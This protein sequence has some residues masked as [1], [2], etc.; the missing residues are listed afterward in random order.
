M[1]ASKLHSFHIPVMGL[2]YTIDTPL[3][4][5]R[6]GISSVV[7]IIEDELVE[8][9]RK[10][11]CEK[12]NIS[13]VPIDEKDVDHRAKRITAYLNLM[14]KILIRQIESLKAGKFEEGSDLV[15]YF[16]MLPDSSPVKELYVL[17][18]K[19]SGSEKEVMQKNLRSKIVAGAIDVNIMTKL[20]KANYNESGEELPVEYCDAMAALRGFAL[21]DLNSSMVF[22]AGLNP[23]LYSYCEVFKDFFQDENGEFRKK[24][25]LKVSDYRSALIQGKFLAKKGLW[26]SEFRIESGLNCGGHAFATEGLLTGPILRE[27]K[28]KKYELVNELFEICNT[29]LREKKLKV[30]TER[31]ELKITFQ[32]GIGTAG[33]NQF[34]LEQYSLDATGW[35]SPFL[36]VPEVT[37]VDEKTLSLLANAVKQD[38]YLSHASPLG[39]PFNNFRRSTAEEQRRMRIEKG[40]PGSPCYKKFLAF[41]TEF[42]SMPI[43]T[44]SR[45]YQNLK[46]KKVK[47]LNLSESVLQ[48][49]IEAIEEKDCLCEGL[50]ASALIKNN[51]PPHHNLTAVT[52]CPGPN[53]AYFSGIFSLE[54]MVSHIYGRKN[55]LNS[56][57]RPNIF[58]NELAL[59]VDYLKQE[60][61]NQR[62]AITGRKNKY[63]T[64]FKENLLHGIQYYKSLVPEMKQFAK[65]QLDA[66]EK[67]LRRFESEITGIVFQQSLAGN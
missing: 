12:E 3:K 6:Y 21:S 29:A 34:L 13:Y 65:S 55:I 51:L 60:I 24:I 48:S 47:E 15:K 38:Y 25:I 2:G 20:D 37:N 45:E 57:R 35:G 54:Q 67:D 18:N 53:L 59:Y 63:F 7:S 23:R 14:N 62:E 19:V 17:M 31:P 43:C 33:E 30:F 36:L 39:I 5:G 41:S 61:Q 49:E 26:V 10:Y 42:T 11:Y 52:I 64:S 4:A 32:G 46:I 9:M 16:E 58:I 66:F 1:I 50:G 40:R 22:S 56:L 27:F 28:E 44:A 8:Q